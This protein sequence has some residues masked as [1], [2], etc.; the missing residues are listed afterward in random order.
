MPTLR[1]LE[2]LVAIADTQHFGRAAIAANVSQPTLSQQLRNLEVRL[3]VTLVERGTTPIQLTPV[4]REITDR[5]RQMVVQVDDIRALA[6]RSISGVAGTIR[7]GVTPTLGPY[8]MPAVIAGMNRT[9]P[10]L[11][12]LIR[13]GIPDEQLAELRRGALDMVLAPMPIGGTDLHIEPLFRE[14]LHLVAASDDALCQK[15]PLRPEDLAGQPVLSLDPRHHFHRQTRAICAELKADLL[16]DYEG[17]SLDSLRQMAGSGL[18]LA[19]LPELYLR[20]EAG[21]EAT[22]RRLAITGWSA[23]RSLAAVWREGA[24]FSESYQLIAEATATEAR[25][26]MESCQ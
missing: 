25:R 14:A 23:T 10:D 12:L 6:Q 15:N 24:A 11:R 21:G 5:A 3:G 4:G 26:I 2:Y 20:S 16:D 17:T 13:E 9:Y 7:F 8:L 19:V 18:G 1:Q 22:I